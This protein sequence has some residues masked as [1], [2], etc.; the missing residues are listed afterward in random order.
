VSLEA[1]SVEIKKNQPVSVE[2]SFSSQKI[3]SF[4]TDIKSELSKIHWTSRAEL[5]AYTKIVIIA[6]F[7]FGMAIYLVDIVIQTI[8]N[9]LSF[10]IQAIV[11]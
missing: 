1:K 7:A 6:T 4:I 3:K 2:S 8:L 11:G 10:I 9:S 5:I